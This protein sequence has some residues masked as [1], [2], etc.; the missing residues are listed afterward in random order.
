MLSLEVK[1]PESLRP[2]ELAQIF[3]DSLPKYRDW[4]YQPRWDD[5]RELLLSEPFNLNPDYI[6]QLRV[7]DV[8]AHLK[9]GARDRAAETDA[10][11]ASTDQEPWPYPAFPRDAL[12][13]IWHFNEDGTT[14]LSNLDCAKEW[15]KLDPQ[16]RERLAPS[17]AGNIATDDTKRAV[18]RVNQAI[19]KAQEKGCQRAKIFEKFPELQPLLQG[20]LMRQT[21]TA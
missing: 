8:V 18:N 4:P 5:V 17:V 12:F 10:A 9:R 13:L 1:R 7:S 3:E 11:E 6:D 19:L 2:L 15:N 14:N 20:H 16:F 21:S